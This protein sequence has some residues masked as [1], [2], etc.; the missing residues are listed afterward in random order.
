[1]KKFIV[2][3]IVSVFTLAI[4]AGDTEEANK[5]EAKTTVSGVIV[6]AETGEALVGV[7]VKMN[8]ETLYTDFDGEF[9]FSVTPGEYTIETDYVSYNSA[10]V[11]V[12]NENS[13]VEIALKGN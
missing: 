13:E 10:K 2:L 1:M 7:A 9:S 6:D 8:G 3:A 4:Y 5:N 12:S 11:D